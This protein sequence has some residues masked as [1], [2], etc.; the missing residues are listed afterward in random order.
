MIF[1]AASFLVRAYLGT[2]A[3]AASYALLVVSAAERLLPVPLRRAQQWSRGVWHGVSAELGCPQRPANGRSEAPNGGPRTPPRGGRE[4][5]DV[6]GLVEDLSRYV[7]SR[8][9]SRPTTPRGVPPSRCS[10]A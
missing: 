6:Q 7:R 1:R 10:S 9:S 3:A 5:P 2:W 4:E 8:A